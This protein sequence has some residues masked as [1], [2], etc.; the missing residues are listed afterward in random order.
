MQLASARHTCQY[1]ADEL[2]CLPGLQKA[3]RVL[4]ETIHCTE[5]QLVDEGLGCYPRM[6]WPATVA[7]RREDLR[8]IGREDGHA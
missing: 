2:S 5:E 7:Y 1:L 4:V 3:L 6:Q 8:R